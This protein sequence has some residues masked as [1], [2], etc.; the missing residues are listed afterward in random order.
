MLRTSTVVL[1]LLCTLFTSAQEK[2]PLIN[3]AEWIQKGVELHDQGKYKDA[4]AAY[5][6]VDRSDTNYYQAVYEMAY[7]Y[8]ADSQAANA[9]KA[10]KIG[11]QKPNEYWP[12]LYNLYGNLLDDDGQSEMA[13][14][15]YDTAI[16]MYPAYTS[17]RLNKGTTYLI[18]KK[19]PEAE[20]VLKECILINPYEG[21]A[22]YKLGL[23]AMA[24]G[25]IME[26]FMSFIN[27]LTLQPNGRF[28]QNCIKQLSN[29]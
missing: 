15:V 19:Y 8:S 25:R 5:S 2:N 10:C 28:Q 23:A 17:L 4:I 11:L 20:A 21:S 22:H 6:K 12:Q 16:R 29:I 3:S 7:S 9:M 26:A 24:Q 1:C 13:L 18:L 27:Y 14:R